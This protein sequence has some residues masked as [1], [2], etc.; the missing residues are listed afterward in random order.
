MKFIGLAIVGLIAIAA[1]LGF[2]WLLSII[3]S[4]LWIFMQTIASIF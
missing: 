1:A 2:I 4:I 3:A